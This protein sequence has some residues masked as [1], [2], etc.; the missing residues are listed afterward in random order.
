MKWKYKTLPTASDAPDGVLPFVARLLAQRGVIGATAVERFLAPDYA[1]DMHDPLLFRDMKKAVAR[2]AAALDA[3]ETIGIFGDHDADGVCAATIVADAIE[4]LGG[5]VEVYIP[6]KVTQ[7]HGI[8][9]DGIDAFARAGVCLMISVDCGTSSHDAVRY[10]GERG[11]DVIITDH[12]HAPDLPPNAY[13]VINPQVAGETYPFRLLS[14]TGVA[15]KVVLALVTHR[16]PD[17]VGRLKWM[18]DVVSVGTI[19]DCVP[20]VGEN[21]VLVHYGLIVLNKTRRTGLA[22]LCAVGRFRKDDAPLRAQTVAFHIA[23][24]INAAGRMRHAAD[25]FALLRDAQAASARRKAYALEQANKQRQRV[26]ATI[27]REVERIVDAEQK[28]AAMIV[29]ANEK[30]PAGII[31]VV[32]GRIAEKYHRPTGI[33]T[34]FGTESRGSF[35]SVEGVHI[36]DV[37]AA[38]SAHLVR[39]G[40]HEKAAGATVTHAAFETFVR[41]A[42][43]YVAALDNVATE[44]SL[45]IDA[46]I[47][48]ADVTVESAEAIASLEPFGEGNPEPVFAVTAVVA[49]MRMVGATGTHVKMTLTDAGGSVYVDAIGFSLRDAC[50]AIA[51]GDTVTVAGMVQTNVWNGIVRPQLQIIAI[52]RAT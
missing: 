11:I 32:A 30:Y 36:V 24:R 7:G 6:D 5:T 48:L 52:R 2:I 8:H 21:R 10:A 44:P 25:A 22:Q 17:A 13:A 45:A 51:V 49:D 18:L 9:A 47:A 39:Y 20:L 41:A 42:N 1:R 43:A 50:A 3:G 19:A 46:E 16:A 40:G 23:P 26:T 34:R 38:C 33:F 37:L 15:F 31:G 29:V 28:D 35:R 4:M 27:T 14:G 12:H